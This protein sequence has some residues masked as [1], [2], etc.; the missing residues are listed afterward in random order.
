MR[1]SPTRFR[2]AIKAIARQGKRDSS[3][4]SDERH[5]FVHGV[6]NDRIVQTYILE[7]KT[8]IDMQADEER[9]YDADTPVEVN[10]SQEGLF[11]DVS[12][13]RATK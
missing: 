4:N 13:K 11:I 2:G 1:N 8:A 12:P 3:W 7:F 6:K 10:D 5:W 9:C